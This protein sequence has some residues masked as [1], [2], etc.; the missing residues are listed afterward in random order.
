[1]PDLQKQNRLDYNG[2]F[3]EL[4]KEVLQRLGDKVKYPAAFNLYDAKHDGLLT[5]EELSRLN[6]IDQQ[7]N[8]KLPENFK[9][10]H[11]DEPNILAHVRFDERTVN[12]ERVLFIEEFQAD[13]GQEWQ[14]L[15]KLIEEGKATKADIDRFEFLDKNF[16]FNKTNVS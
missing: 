5:Q 1:M 3:I 7:A 13:K 12:G 4:Q 2:R 16:P 14:K 8:K 15:K 6:S 11:F 10:S 9:S